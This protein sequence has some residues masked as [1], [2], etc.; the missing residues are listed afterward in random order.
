[1]TMLLRRFIILPTLL[2]MALLSCS[3]HDG[4]PY[5]TI[6]G[7]PY[8]T[9]LYRLSGGI[10]VFVTR[11]DVQPRATVALCLP[12]VACD[13]LERLFTPSVRSQ[14]YRTL[15]ATIGTDLCDVTGI[16]G[17]TIVSNDIPCNETENWA[18]IIRGT[19]VALP[20][21]AA[22]V[23]SGAVDPEATVAAVERQL[24]SLPL[25]PTRPLVVDTAAADIRFIRS[26]CPANVG[27]S[28]L[29]EAYNQR[30]AFG[31]K[32]NGF[33]AF[34]IAEAILRGAAWNDAYGRRKRLES[35]NDSQFAMLK[36]LPLLCR[37]SR[38]PD[39]M[40]GAENSITLLP[41][42][43]A[44]VLFPDTDKLD[45]SGSDATKYI[46][47]ETDDTLFTLALRYNM[48]QLPPCFTALVAGYLHDKFGGRAAVQSVDGTLQLRLEG[49]VSN[50]SAMV[51]QAL[52]ALD[53]MLGNKNLYKNLLS[54]KDAVAS[55]K[56]NP[57]NIAVQFARYI[58]DGQSLYGADDAVARCVK[59][60]LSLPT[61]LLYSGNSPQAAI[62]T[63]VSRESTKENVTVSAAPGDTVPTFCLLPVD[64]DTP[65]GI[66]ATA[67]VISVADH[68]SI[69]LFNKAASLAGAV[70][71]YFPEGAYCCRD[72]AAAGLP[73]TRVELDAAKSYLLYGC[74]TQK[75]YG[76]PLAEEYAAAS[77][78]GYT[79]SQL[80]DALCSLDCSDVE[81]F[82]F[83][84]TDRPAARLVV[85]RQS[86]VMQEE[87]MTHLTS[88]ELF[89][90]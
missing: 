41:S 39:A 28:G 4:R 71:R 73:F 52:A 31:E 26:L 8:A 90:Y 62:K 59:K 63:L 79:A 67:P 5:S 36:G 53:A 80:Y 13:T 75:G 17:S 40:A 2:L 12:S 49:A 10:R 81:D 85:G 72:T 54:D 42:P 24:A 37:S 23:V 44:S 74:S 21:S 55:L 33:R 34:A 30:L 86:S 60:L 18:R 29:K 69:L 50:Q 65:I 45:I 1:M 20:D 38:M 87:R 64:T 61:E 22:V 27:L 76:Y 88:D 25:M 46:C 89:G 19:F 84:Q 58:H 66:F 56:N 3:S 6:A 47:Y 7:D 15:F 70:D 51:G 48:E 9:R 32:D 35:M 14:K 43:P 68:A 77:L 82:H 11:N 16:Y 83:R 57:Y 78:R